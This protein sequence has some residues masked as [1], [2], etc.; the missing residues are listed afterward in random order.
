MVPA[1]PVTFSITIGWPSASARPGHARR[2]P[3][4]V[5]HRPRPGG[6]YVAAL[7][8]PASAAL[9][10]A[11]LVVKPVLD[12]QRDCIVG[13]AVIRSRSSAASSLLSLASARSCI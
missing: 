7:L 8:L 10:E 4:E 12:R 3:A 1:A 9:M 11:A 6:G 13:L 5:P 2:L